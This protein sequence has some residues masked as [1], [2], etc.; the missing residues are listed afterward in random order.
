[1]AAIP[2][3]IPVVTADQVTAA[4]AK[5]LDVAAPD[6]SAGV[7]GQLSLI[8]PVTPA[9][10]S[11]LAD[12]D[13]SDS[14]NFPARGAAVSQ[15]RERGSF[16]L[17]AIPKKRRGRPPGGQPAR[18]KPMRRPPQCVICRDSRRAQIEL[19]IAC[20][21]P[22]KEI[23]ERFGV[24]HQS[25]YLHRTRHL[26]AALQASLAQ[27]VHR[28]IAE[29]EELR[30]DE[31]KGLLSRLVH[32]RHKLAIL[33]EQAEAEKQYGHANR[34]HQTLLRLHAQEARILHLV[35][36][37]NARTI[38]NNLTISPEYLTLRSG[39]LQALAKHPGARQDVIR[40]L[41]AI[42]SDGLRRIEQAAGVEL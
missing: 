2:A 35:D 21:F 13:A 6:D 34:I 38:N 9:S 32:Q 24:G 20:G 40:V 37:E 19:D 3:L 16:E 10:A 25:V 28:T 39:L 42:E 23:A 1:M 33:L 8:G 15:K 30:G 41:T 27:K 17:H 12:S 5:R 26:S 14:E 7:T 11:R 36:N 4:K 18:P 31:A 22:R 29:S